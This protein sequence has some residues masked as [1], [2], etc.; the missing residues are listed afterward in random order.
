MKLFGSCLSS[1]IFL[2]LVAPE[3]IIAVSST[4][5]DCCA[6]PDIRRIRAFSTLAGG[7]AIFLPY[8][9]PKDRPLSSIQVVLSSASG[10]FLSCRG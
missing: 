4:E 5:A 3:L 8:V 10:S 9:S 6:V 7:N 2:D 1:Q